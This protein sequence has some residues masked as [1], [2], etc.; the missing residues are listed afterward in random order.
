MTQYRHESGRVICV[1][2]ERPMSIY[3][4]DIVYEAYTKGQEGLYYLVSSEHLGSLELLSHEPLNASNESLKI[5]PNR[6]H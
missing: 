4:D 5:H 3:G 2:T 6:G 1:K